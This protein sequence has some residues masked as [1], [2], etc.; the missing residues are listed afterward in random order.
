MDDM[1]GIAERLPAMS[2]ETAGRLERALD[3]TDGAHNRTDRAHLV[4][5][6]DSLLDL[7]RNLA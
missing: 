6:R 7:A 4:A 1:V 5:K 2:D 3:G